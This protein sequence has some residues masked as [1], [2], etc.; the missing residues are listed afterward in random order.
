MTRD[1]TKTITPKELR[2]LIMLEIV[3]PSSQFEDER[4]SRLERTT[5]Y[6]RYKKEL[7]KHSCDWDYVFGEVKD[8]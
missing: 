1:A 6:E 7:E 5:I 3:A 2:N 8:E 4:L